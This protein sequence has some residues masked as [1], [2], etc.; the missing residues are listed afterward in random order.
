MR[1]SPVVSGD[2]ASLEDLLS[3]SLRALFSARVAW[4]RFSSSEVPPCAFL[5]ASSS[6]TARKDKVGDGRQSRSWRLVGLRAFS[7]EAVGDGLQ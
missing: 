7:Q 1:R 6:C 5:T 4:R 2:E 3:S